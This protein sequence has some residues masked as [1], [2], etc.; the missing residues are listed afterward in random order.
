MHLF[1]VLAILNY[2]WIVDLDICGG[3]DK[4]RRL[5]ITTVLQ[6]F[7]LTPEPYLDEKFKFFIRTEM[8]YLCQTRPGNYSIKKKFGT[9]FLHPTTQIQ[10]PLLSGLDAQFLRGYAQLC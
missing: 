10:M 1:L 8:E 4:K 2:I 5:I 3:R 9:N 7:L 6:K